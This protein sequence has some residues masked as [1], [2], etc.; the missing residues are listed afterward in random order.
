MGSGG[1]ISA[2][3]D[4]G[5]DV[6]GA[7]SLS[8]D[9]LSIGVGPVDFGVGVDMFFGDCLTSSPDW[10]FPEARAQVGVEVAE[11]PRVHKVKS[12]DQVIRA[13]IQAPLNED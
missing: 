7:S 5:D 13:P 8:L 2:G 9:M 6:W 3:F 1:I 10:S 12:D 4:D 11:E